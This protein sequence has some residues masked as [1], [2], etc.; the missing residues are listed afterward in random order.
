MLEALTNEAK[1]TMSCIP[2]A[3]ASAR[4]Y[5][6]KGK[7]VDVVANEFSKYSIPRRRQTKKNVTLLERL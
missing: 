5:I 4:I 2:A 1:L 3:N 7:P 6:L